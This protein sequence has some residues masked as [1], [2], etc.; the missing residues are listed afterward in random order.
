VAVSALWIAC[1]ILTFAFPLLRRSAG[2]TAAFWL[3]A[4]CF[5]GFV[6]VRAKVPGRGASLGESNRTWG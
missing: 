2:I 5:A 1:C 4:V 3:A 6:F